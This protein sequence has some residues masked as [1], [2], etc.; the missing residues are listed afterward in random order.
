MMLFAVAGSLEHTGVTEIIAHN[1][2]GTFGSSNTVLTPLIIIMTAVGSAFV[3]NIVFVAAF[4]PVVKELDSTP[5]WWAL[6]FGACFGGN[7]TAIGSTANIVALGMLEKRYR[8]HIMFLEWLKV[9]AIVGLMTCIIA[10]IGIV[11]LTPF[12][13]AM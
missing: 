10:W 9:G 13:P 11:I 6:L 8:A 5:L 1:F 4:I 3:D 7:I 12:M 2:K